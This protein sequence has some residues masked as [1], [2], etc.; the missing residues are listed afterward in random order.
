MARYAILLGYGVFDPSNSLY[1]RYIR[2]FASFVNKNRISTVVL[3]GG[4]TNPKRPAESEA[5]SMADY[6]KPLLKSKVKV[7]LEDKSINTVQNIEFSK[8]FV[9]ARKDRVTIFCDN[10][11]TPKVMW[12][13]MH[14]WFGMDK[15]QAEQYFVDL[16]LKYYTKHLSTEQIGERISGGLDY[17]NVAI[18]TYRMR[19]RIEHAVSQQIATILEINS[20]YD[21]VLYRK[22]IRNMRVKFGFV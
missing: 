1:K 22:L 2:N 20:L 13:V 5:G 16:G 3:C 18:R 6:L 15:A 7:L 4:R 10:I 14:F 8:R 21:K 12:F 19:S 9:D 11:R 17:K